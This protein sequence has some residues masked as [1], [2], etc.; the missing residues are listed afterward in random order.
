[1]SGTNSSL[2]HVRIV[3][4]G[5][6]GS[7]IGLALRSHGISVSMVDRDSAAQA[8]AI[9]LMGGSAALPSK[10]LEVDLVLIA[11]PASSIIE[12]IEAEYA[13]NLNST[14]M[15]V[16]SIKS[17]PK[18]DVSQSSLPTSRFL[19]SHPMAGREIGGP[20]SARGDLFQGCIWA[21]DPKGVDERSLSLGL[22]LIAL[23]GASP[24]SIASSEHDQAVA[25]ASHL[26]QAVSTLL[27]GQLVSA[28]DAHLDLAGGG[29]RDT[30]R[31]AASSPAL[32]SEILSSNAAALRPLLLNL[33]ED[34]SVL[35]E[36]LDDPS[37]LATFMLAGNQGRARIPGKHGGAS[38]SYTY[39]PVVIE[40]KPGQL[41]ALFEECAQAGVNVEDLT[42]EHSPEQFTGLIT[43]ALSHDDATKLFSHLEGIGWKVHAPRK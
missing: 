10:D 7:S 12:V 19:P 24:L 34:L 28:K 40:D 11:T 43:L 15:D 33:Q 35:I 8:L 5:L 13:L 3:G 2:R 27:A 30:T 37:F 20:E 36:N 42:I 17:K 1:M 14:F 18:S 29:L 38:R 23:C 26:P 32:W 41:A 6:I 16:S 39:L 9:D 21:Y 25:L 31:I 4:S 22:E